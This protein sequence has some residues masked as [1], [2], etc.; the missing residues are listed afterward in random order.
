V[1]NQRQAFAFHKRNLHRYTEEVVVTSTKSSSEHVGLKVIC[2]AVI[3]AEALLGGV[4]P[5]FLVKYLAKTDALMALMNAFSGG[6]FLTA[7][8]THI[9]PH[10][11]GLYK[12]RIQLPVD[13]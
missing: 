6:V 2:L 9:L 5:L 3:F 1:R 8:L 13:S 11:V 7:G 10:V 12:L 4:L